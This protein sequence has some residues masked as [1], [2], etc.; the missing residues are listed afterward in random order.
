MCILH[1]CDNP[2]CVNPDHVHPGTKGDNYRD[3]VTRGRA[4]LL[5]GGKFG[6]ENARAIFTDEDVLDIRSLHA[7]GARPVDL[8]KEFKTSKGYIWEIVT[9]VRWRHLP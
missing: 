8:A 6:V 2:P 4:K 1:K 9:K 3:M 5:T 7:L